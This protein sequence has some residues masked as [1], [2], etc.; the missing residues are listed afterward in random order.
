LYFVEYANFN[1]QAT[2]NSSLT[3]DGYRQGG[4]GAGVTNTTSAKWNAF[5]GYNP[6]IPCGVTIPLGNSTGVVSYTFAADEYETG[7]AYTTNIPS[8][9]GIE[10]PFGHI[11][12]F[13]D[14]FNRQGG[15]DA[16]E[17]A[18]EKIYTCNDVSKFAEN[19]ADGYTLI[20]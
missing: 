19:A 18:I 15:L 6:F 3:A 8:Y 13:I 12:K 9:R 20:S 4:L 7:A 1:S 2:F 10:N 14:G 17:E 16:N 11:W 5:N